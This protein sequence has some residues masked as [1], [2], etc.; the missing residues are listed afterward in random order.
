MPVGNASP[1]EITAKPMP[2]GFFRVPLAGEFD[3]GVGGHAVRGAGGRGT[4]SGR[5]GGVRG[6]ATHGVH[7]LARRGQPRRRLRSRGTCRRR[8]T[9]VNARGLVK[10]V[11]D[12]TGL[13]EVL[14][15]HEDPPTP[16]DPAS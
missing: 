4:P 13:S 8:F 9:A 1:F 7:R 10:E 6:C 2:G 5:H 16:V 11:L 14:F 12:I 15:D 3:M